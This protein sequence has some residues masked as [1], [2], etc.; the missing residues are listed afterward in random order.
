MGHLP[1]EIFVFSDLCNYCVKQNVVLP[2]LEA[3]EMGIE[4]P[5]IY[6]VFHDFFLRSSVGDTAWKS[7]CMESSDLTER[8]APMQ[9]EAF[10]MLLLKNNYFAW[11]W[12]AK[13]NYKDILV[14]DYDS[15]NERK[16]KENIG[17]AYVKLEVNLEPNE[18]G[19]DDVTTSDFKDVLVREGDPTYVE[20]HR[21]TQME[22][23][24]VRGIARGNAKYKDL[25]KQ[26]E[27]ELQERGE[28]DHVFQH[29]AK[30]RKVLKSFR[31]YTNPQDDEGRFK[32]WS[33]RAAVDM[34][35]LIAKVSVDGPRE[36]KFRAGYRLT[37]REKQQSSA[38]KKRPAQESTMVNYEN[39]IWGLDETIGEI[40]AL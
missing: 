40:E 4:I 37:Y 12:E 1:Y 18:G 30:R 3:F 34:K 7:A 24:K 19:T 38:K 15:D 2:S 29:K 21:K 8:L 28:D 26:L 36:K 23:K 14:T 13:L 35:E 33:H 31:E 6:I 39:D 20:L 22:L 25:L 9:G 27:E 17:D 5:S 10:A 16:N 11:L 32:G